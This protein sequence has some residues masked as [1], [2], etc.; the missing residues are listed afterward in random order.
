[1]IKQFKLIITD[2]NGK[3]V[4]VN[5]SKGFSPQEIIGLL[6]LEKLEQLLRI[7]KTGSINKS[8]GFKDG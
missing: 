4:K 1:M 3:I 5:N 7:K 6:E 2:N 8:G